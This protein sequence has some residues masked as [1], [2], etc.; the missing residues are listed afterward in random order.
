MPG[1][2][3]SNGDVWAITA[4]QRRPEIFSRVVALSPG[5]HPQRVGRRARA[6]GVRH[7]PAAGLLEPAFL[8]SAQTW[9]DRL[10]RAGLDVRLDEVHGGHDDLWWR[11]HLVTGLAHL[12]DVGGPR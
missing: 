3:S 8:Q 9:T 11:E 1:A 2:G 12:E 4:A 7:Y 10:R 6:A 5:M